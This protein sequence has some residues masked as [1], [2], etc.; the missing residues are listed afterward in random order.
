MPFHL[1]QNIQEAF[2]QSPI[3]EGPS[4]NTPNSDDF[5]ENLNWSNPALRGLGCVYCALM[6]NP[7]V[8]AIPK[9]DPRVYH[10]FHLFYPLEK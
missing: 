8:G 3:I 10:I 2:S 7:A 1:V 4:S 5:N 6:L 9:N